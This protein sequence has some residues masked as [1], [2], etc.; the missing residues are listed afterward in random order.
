MKG[1]TVRWTRLTPGFDWFSLGVKIDGLTARVPDVGPAATDFRSQEV[2][3]RLK[4]LPLLSRRVEVSSAKVDGVWVTLTEQPPPP[5]GAPGTPPPPPLQISLPRV[6]FHNVNVRT[7]DPLGSGMELKNLNGN[8]VFTGTLDAPRS[9]E[10]SAKADSLFWKPSA[11]AASMPLPSPLALETAFQATGEPGSLQVKRGTL[12]V[13]PLRS[14]IQGTVRF[15]ARGEKGGPAVN[16][17][18]AG[19]PQKIDSGDEAFRGL[20]KA[21]PAKWAGTASWKIHAGGRAPEIVTDGS[22]ILSGLAVEAQ[23]NSF[24]IDQVKSVWNTRADR[25]FT[26]TGSGGGSGISLSFDA[27]GLLTPGGAT[28]GS[29]LVRAPATRLNG[30]VPNTPKW[31]SGDLEARAL[32]ELKP[33]AKPEIRWTVRGSGLDGTM[34]G[35]THPMRGL[36]F[37]AEGTD[38]A[39]NLKSMRVQIGSS[40]MNLSGT[41]ARGKPLG[42]GTFAFQMDKLIAEEWAPPAADGKA[43]RQVMAPPPTAMPIPLGAFTGTVS[44]GEVR[45]GTMRAT[46][47]TA[48]VRYDGT[49][50]VVAPLQGT[51]GTGSFDGTFNVHTPFQKPSYALHMDVKKAPVEQVAAGT[52]PFSSAVSGFLTGALD[53]SGDGFPSPKPNDTLKGLLNGKVEDGT[54]KLTPTVVAVA[55][56]LGITL[57]AELPLTQATHTVRIAGSRLLIDKAN[58]DLGPDKAEMNG[59]VALDHTIDLNV[60][61]RLAPN[62]VKGSSVLAKFAQYARDSEGRLPVGLKIAGLDRAPKI[63]VNT[64]ALLAAATK[65]MKGELGKKAMSQLMSRL[66]SRTDSLHKQDSTLVADSTRQAQTPPRAD[67]TKADPVKK[68]GDALK[69]ILGR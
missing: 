61:L 20:A 10:I 5:E 16:L 42:T 24:R 3:V 38:V 34:Q 6:D 44:I 4:L 69:R 48:P 30:I 51:L 18:L 63:T 45:S 56:A 41:V 64:E 65:Q 54:V 25:T 68:A 40:T 21:S 29:I 12:D 31:T 32:F 9:I 59:S 66:E 2:F 35:L 60:L 57:P 47:V 23:G 14:T 28:S 49:N 50:L 26:A 46:N 8:A 55:Q 58:G 33:P 62:R 19:N 39:A 37:D 7:R 11:A 43:P 27:K 36:Q 13:G 17:E 15:P 67:S 1:A 52:I 22:F 53:L